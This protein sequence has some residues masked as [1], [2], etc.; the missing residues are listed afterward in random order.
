M[1]IDRIVTQIAVECRRTNVAWVYTMRREGMGVILPARS[2]RILY[3]NDVMSAEQRRE[4]AARV[5]QTL[6]QP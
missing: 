6:K 2:V 3:R 5:N 1:S 4:L